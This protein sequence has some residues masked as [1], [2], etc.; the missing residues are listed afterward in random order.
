MEDAIIR[1]LLGLIA[2][3]VVLGI[4]LYALAAIVLLGAV[5]SLTGGWAYVV[6]VVA[7]ALEERTVH[8]EH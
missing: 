8:R 6:I 4:A 5:A 1:V 2:A 3:T 7:I